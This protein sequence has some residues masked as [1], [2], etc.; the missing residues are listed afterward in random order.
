MKKIL[1]ALALFASFAVNCSAQNLTTVSGSNITDINGARLAAGQLCF[2]ITDQSDQPIS[3]SI[4]GGGQALRRGYC[5][6]IAAGVVTTFTVPNPAN[7]LP[8]GI[9]YRVTVKDSS[10]GLEVLRYTQV[11]FTGA[12]FNFDNYAPQNLGTPAPLSGNSVTGNLSVTGNVAATGTVTGT[13]IPS[14]ILQQIFNAGTG[15]TQ[16]TAFN[17]L[18]GVTCSD[19]AGTLR[20]DCRAGGLNTVTFAATPAFDASINSM[21]KLTLTGNVTS[22]T[23]SN[24]IAG[25]QLSFEIC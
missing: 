2:L 14:S 3:V 9:Y 13:N 10:S 16:R 20:T 23:L 5:S 19:N 12:T 24:A 11:S 17:M 4:G 1:L 6:P 15:L 21:F 25:E 7:T 8:S 22:S 18:A